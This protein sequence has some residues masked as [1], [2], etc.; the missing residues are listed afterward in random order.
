MPL[1]LWRREL[2]VRWLTDARVTGLAAWLLVA[3]TLYVLVS[4]WYEAAI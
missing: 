3:G 1:T 4:Y 2:V